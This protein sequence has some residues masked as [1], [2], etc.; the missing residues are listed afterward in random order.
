MNLTIRPRYFDNRVK[1]PTREEAIRIPLEGA[2][3]KQKKN[4]QEVEVSD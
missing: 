1:N 4:G 3:T 2:K